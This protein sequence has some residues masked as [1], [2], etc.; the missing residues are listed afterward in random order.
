MI[1]QSISESAVGDAPGLLWGALGPRERSHVLAPTRCDEH[2]QIPRACSELGCRFARGHRGRGTRSYRTLAAPFH[3][4]SFD[5]RRL[6]QTS[7]ASSASQHPPPSACSPPVGGRGGA[8]Q[9][10]KGGGVRRGRG[11][12]RVDVCAHVLVLISVMA[13]IFLS[14][15]LRATVPYRKYVRYRTVPYRM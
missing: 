3:G 13:A 1:A 9:G 12:A 7:R 8:R 10:R 2:V 15:S 11:K 6:L 5:G 14:L 4:H